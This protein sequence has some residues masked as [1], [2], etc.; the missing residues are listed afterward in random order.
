MFVIKISGIQ[1]KYMY[2]ENEVTKGPS[3]LLDQDIILVDVKFY[4][5]AN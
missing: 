1:K 5:G 4:F 3:K 2:I